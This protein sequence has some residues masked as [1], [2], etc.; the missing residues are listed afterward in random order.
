[1]L[2]ICVKMRR[3]RSPP[4]AAERAVFAV[5][6]HVAHAPAGLVAG[7]GQ[8]HLIIDEECGVEQ[9]N[10]RAVEPRAQGAVHAGGARDVEQPAVAAGELDADIG[11]G[12]RGERGIVA[13]EIERHLAGDGEQLDIKAARQ[14]K[15]ARR[16]RQPC[17]SP[18]AGQHP[19]DRIGVQ[20]R[21][22]FGGGKHRETLAFAQRQQAG[23]LIDLGAGQDH[24][25]DRTAARAGPRL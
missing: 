5:E 15:T 11:L 6:R 8:D 23:H 19:E 17:A 1:M 21:K 7:A 22:R 2:L 20:R 24:G 4:S 18:V 16:T 3:P 9:Y 12:F 13:L 14:R 10:V 25:G